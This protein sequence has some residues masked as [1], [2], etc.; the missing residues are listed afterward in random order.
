M[1]TVKTNAELSKLFPS[2]A[3]PFAVWFNY[4]PHGDEHGSWAVNDENGDAFDMP[5]YEGAVKVAAAFKASTRQY[6]SLGN[7]NIASEKIQKLDA[8]ICAITGEGFERF[9]YMEDDAQQ[10]YLQAISDYSMAINKAIND[11]A[12]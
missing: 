5:S 2:S 1:N 3:E 12:V 7:Y 6:I 9:K 10:W 4:L 11:G 8:M